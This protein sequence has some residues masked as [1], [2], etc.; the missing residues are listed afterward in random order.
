VYSLICVIRYLIGLF[1]VQFDLCDS[2]FDRLILM[3]LCAAISTPHLQLFWWPT[4]TGWRRET[5]KFEIIRKK[6]EGNLQNFI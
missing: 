6:N 5:V 4:C 1:C 2:L 3:L